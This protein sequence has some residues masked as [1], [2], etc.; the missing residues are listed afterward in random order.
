MKIAMIAAMS[1]NRVIGINNDLPWHLPDDMKYFMETTKHHC[2][3][4]G[5]KNYESLPPKFRPLPDRT[6]LVVTRQSDYEA[7]GCELFKNIEATV[8]FAKQR[9]EELLFIIGGGQIYKQGINIADTIYLTEI[10]AVIEGGE[11]FFPELD[12]SWVEVS[13]QHH[14]A[15]DRHKYSFDF[16]KYEKA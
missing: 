8:D 5:R 9:G 16:V 14:A 13:R 4:M 11:V 10:D 1:T 12:S 7:P 15:D 2:V 6:N 3:V